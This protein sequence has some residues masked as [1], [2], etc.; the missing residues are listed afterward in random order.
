MAEAGQTL[1]RS[2]VLLMNIRGSARCSCFR[3]QTTKVVLGETTLG[4]FHLNLGPLSSLESGEAHECHVKRHH[5]EGGK[6][7][8][9]IMPPK[10]SPVALPGPEV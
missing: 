9:H 3:T 4:P 8:A 7:E 6:L 10:V 1:S 5:K 2:S